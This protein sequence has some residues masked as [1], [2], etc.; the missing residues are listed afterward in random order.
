MP[1][2]RSR[3]PSRSVATSPVIATT[4]GSV[5]ELVE[6]GRTG[7]LGSTDDELVAALGE[8][9]RLERATCRR[10]AEDRFSIDRVAAEHVDLDRQVIAR[11]VVEQRCLTASAAVP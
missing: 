6:H 10:V 3:S 7:L 5:P 2:R 9:G 8:V 11:G 1:A 4:R